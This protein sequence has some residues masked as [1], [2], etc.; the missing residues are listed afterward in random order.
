VNTVMNL[1]R[2]G[3]PYPSD[4]T[5]TLPGTLLYGLSEFLDENLYTI[6]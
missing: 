3:I 6:G 4:G 1:Y 5:L 2:K